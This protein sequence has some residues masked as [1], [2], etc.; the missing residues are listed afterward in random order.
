MIYI[1]F[2]DNYTIGGPQSFLQNL[3]DH[4]IAVNYPY[5]E[6][7]EGCKAIFFPIEYDI[8]QLKEL[9]KKGIKIIQRLDGVYYPTKHGDNYINLNQNIRDIYL[10]YSDFVVFQSEYSRK[11]CFKVLGS[12]AQSK[13]QIIHNGVKKP[14]FPSS[15]YNKLETTDKIKF[16]TTGNFRNADMIEPVVKAFDMLASSMAFELH[17]VGPI[18]ENLKPLL[19]KAY[20]NHH[21]NKTLAEV[22]EILRTCHA[23]IYSHLNPP[24]PNSVLEAISCGLPVVGFDSGAMSELCWFG[25]DLLAPVSDDMIQVY[26][27]FKPGKLAEK[28]ELCIEKYD[29]Y[30]QNALQHAHLYS[31]NECGAKYIEV[32][33]EQL[34]QYH[35]PG[36]L[37]RIFKTQKK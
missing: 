31:F 21:D 27:D 11:Q 32:F 36:F 28:I 34:Q 9:K 15:S 2:P 10:N 13:Y 22:G 26:E 6:Q 1:P 19:Y 16:I 35:K 14:T 12:I 25:K 3:H 18:N 33:E 17:I 8:L 7:I 5:S 20:I 24:C 29:Y 23:F 37:K 30:R 4:L